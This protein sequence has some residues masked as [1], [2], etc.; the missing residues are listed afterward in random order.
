M[1][2]QTEQELYE[3]ELLKLLNLALE[4]VENVK[5]GC[6]FLLKDLFKGHEWKII[7]NSLKTKLSTKFYLA[8]KK[9]DSIEIIDNTGMGYQKYKKI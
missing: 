9:I 2:N 5:N 6:V 3:E 1:R 8:A 7:E 4:E